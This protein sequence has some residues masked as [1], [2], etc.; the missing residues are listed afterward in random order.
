MLN[1]KNAVVLSGGEGA[2]TEQRKPDSI[3]E[4]QNEH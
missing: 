3:C 2:T 4:L 1:G